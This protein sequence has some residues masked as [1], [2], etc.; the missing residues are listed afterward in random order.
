V[1]TIDINV[2]GST[3]L[4]TKLTIDASEKTS[5]TAAT[6]YVISGAGKLKDDDEVTIDIDTAGT[7]AKGL[8][9]CVV[10]EQ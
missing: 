7:G 4:S 3:I 8:I 2:N 1:V 5:T 6:S 9:V 10:I